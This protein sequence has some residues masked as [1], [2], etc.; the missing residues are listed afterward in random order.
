M[1]TFEQ[2]LKTVLAGL[3]FPAKK[4]QIIAAC[5]KNAG[6]QKTLDALDKSLK[7]GQEY[8]NIREINNAMANTMMGR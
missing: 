6:D 2:V 3:N 4:E 8:K 7:D 5:K 1:F